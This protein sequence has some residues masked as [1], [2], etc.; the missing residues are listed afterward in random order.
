MYENFDVSETLK[1]EFERWNNI[2]KIKPETPFAIAGK[3]LIDF[4]EIDL[5]FDDPTNELISSYI[6]YP[7]DKICVDCLDT[8]P[9]NAIRS[10]NTRFNNTIAGLHEDIFFLAIKLKYATMESLKLAEFIL[11][12]R[13]DIRQNATQFAIGLSPILQYADKIVIEKY[14]LL[15]QYYVGTSGLTLK[16]EAYKNYSPKSFYIHPDEIQS[17]TPNYTAGKEKE[18]KYIINEIVDRISFMTLCHI[19]FFDTA[20][21][22]E[23]HDAIET[24][25]ARKGLGA[26]KAQKLIYDDIQS[27]HLNAIQLRHLASD[28]AQNF[29]NFIASMTTNGDNVDNSIHTQPKKPDYKI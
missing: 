13:Q 9:E 20:L 4:G 28:T 12:E 26:K 14:E 7:F 27:I 8:I 3:A 24:D 1:V 16:Y 15:D 25:P 6:F 11:R 22:L 21:S 18:I 29:S 5:T 17:I 23:F 19:S 2:N 10:I